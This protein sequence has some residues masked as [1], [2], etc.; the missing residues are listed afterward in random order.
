MPRPRKC[1][2]NE[3]S[4]CTKLN[5]NRE[6]HRK[7]RADPE[8]MAA[9]RVY[10]REYLRRRKIEEPEFRE[11][12]RERS[13]KG[14]E[15]RRQRVKAIVLEAKNRPCVDC[16]VRH[17]PAAMDLDHVHGPKGFGMSKFR[18]KYATL[19]EVRAEIAKCEVRCANCHRIRHHPGSWQE[20]A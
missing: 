20:A 17:P 12:A 18:Q 13:R 5:R 9:Y 4:Y 6:W 15:A 16:G 11:V 19:D 14:S 1:E 10:Q 8:W 7:K 3:C 2:C